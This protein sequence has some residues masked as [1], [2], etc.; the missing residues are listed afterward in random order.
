M[1]VCVGV[2]RGHGLHGPRRAIGC[3]GVAVACSRRR[4]L[5][6]VGGHEVGLC[7]NAVAAATPLLSRSCS[8]RAPQDRRCAA[9]EC[10]YPIRSQLFV[11]GSTRAGD[12]DQQRGSN[13]ETSKGS[14]S[15]CS[16][17]WC[18]VVGSLTTAPAS[19]LFPRRPDRRTMPS[20]QP[21]ST[22]W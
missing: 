6:G 18:S 11:A 12:V 9:W 16:V 19:S 8:F 5:Y 10:C 4:I 14:A 7:V 2:S 21:G 3:A 13:R 20:H 22:R 15:R 1:V 17:A